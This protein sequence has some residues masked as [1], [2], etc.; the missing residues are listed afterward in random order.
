MNEKTESRIDIEA[1]KALI[2]WKSLFADEV[3][4]GAK[5]LAMESGE[6]ACITISHYRRAAQ[7]AIGSLSGVLLDREPSGDNQKAA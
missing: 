5:R 6:Q 2:R 3:A 7:L 1:V 4:Q